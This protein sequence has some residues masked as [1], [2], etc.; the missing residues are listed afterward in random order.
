MSR[1]FHTGV[2]LRVPVASTCSET[3]RRNRQWLVAAIDRKRSEVNSR[4]IVTSWIKSVN[5]PMVIEENIF[6]L[7][8][9]SFIT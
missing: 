4:M 8:A 1:R 9:G 5:S 7:P 3:E 6:S 2:A